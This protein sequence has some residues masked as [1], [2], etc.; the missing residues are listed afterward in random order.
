MESSIKN[1]LLL[2]KIFKISTESKKLIFNKFQSYEKINWHY[3]ASNLF[4]FGIENSEKIELNH[5]NNEKCKIYLD[6]LNKS[7]IQTISPTSVFF[8]TALHH[9]KPVVKMLFSKGNKQLLDPSVKKVSIV[10][11]RKP[12]AY[13]RKIAYDLG[14][15]LACHGVCVVSGMALGID[16]QAHKGALDVN[17][18]TIAVLASGVNHI[19]PMTNEKIYYNIIEENGL[20]LSEQFI[21]EFPLKWHFPLRNRIISALSDVV[22]IIEA[23]DKSGSLITAIH[24]LEQGKSVFALPGSIL[25]PQSTGSNKLIYEGAMP[26]INFSHILEQLDIKEKNVKNVQLDLHHLSELAQKIYKLLQLNQRIDFDEIYTAFNC[27]YSEINSAVSELILE[28]L[29]EYLSLNEIHLV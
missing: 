27:E 9:Y 28:E 1:Y 18:D 15:Y 21:D 5:D 25:S 4:L 12:T 10:G 24:A 14:R 2:E 17:G 13:G 29:C 19:Y 26:L 16:A 11:S 8:P 6:S 7:D 22:V 23:G 20:I 3:V